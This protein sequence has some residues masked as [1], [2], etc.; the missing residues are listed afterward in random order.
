MLAIAPNDRS[1][2]IFDQDGHHI[3]RFEGAVDIVS[4]C[5]ATE[6]NSLAGVAKDGIVKWEAKSWKPVRF[7]PVNGERL[8]DI[9][10][11]PQGDRVAIGKGRGQFSVFELESGTEIASWKAHISSIAALA[12]VFG[13]KRL[14][15]S[16]DDATI[17]V[18]NPGNGLAGFR[19]DGHVDG[20]RDIAVSDDEEWILSA[21]EDRTIRLWATA[22]N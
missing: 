21:S 15:T 10:F 16:G 12:F 17:T 9:A 18:W 14:I 2:L 6:S 7:I 20:V 5:F 19:L 1:P 22:D 8:S 13:G 11:A 3:T 4:L